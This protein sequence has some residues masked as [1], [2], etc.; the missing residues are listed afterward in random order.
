MLWLIAEMFQAKSNLG[1][2]G[3][4]QRENFWTTQVPP[5]PPLRSPGTNEADKS[6]HELINTNQ[7]L[8]TTSHNAGILRMFTH[9]GPLRARIFSPRVNR[10]RN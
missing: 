2:N 5:P 8:A 4:N 10:L 7:A 6:G 1:W 9:L 3:D